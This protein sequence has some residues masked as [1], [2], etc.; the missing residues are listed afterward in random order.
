MDGISPGQ[1][2]SPI[3]AFGSG[4]VEAPLM[5]LQKIQVAAIVSEVEDWI[6]KFLVSWWRDDGASDAKPD[7]GENYYP[8]VFVDGIA[9]LYQVQ[10]PWLKISTFLA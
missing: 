5:I 6:E 1:V 3:D 10:Q 9:L 2:V 7:C 4:S 8:S